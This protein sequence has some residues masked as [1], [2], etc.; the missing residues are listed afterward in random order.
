MT[1]EIKLPV[2]VK[3]M[4][5]AIEQIDDKIKQQKTEIHQ[6]EKQFQILKKLTFSFIENTKKP[7][8]KTKKPSGFMLP[9]LISPELCKFLNIDEG[10]HAARTEVTRYLIQYIQE[11]NLTH[12]DK[13]TLVI[14]D[15]PL[16]DLLGPDLDLDTL[17]RFTMQKCMNRHFITNSS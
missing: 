11:H 17:T 3:K 2:N 13:K 4:I 10:S 7:V 9:V 6:M 8:K 16:A 15:E 1:E 14:P 5:S 12:P